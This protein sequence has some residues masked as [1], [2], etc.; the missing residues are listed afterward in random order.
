MGDS[1]EKASLWQRLW[2]GPA[3]WFLGIL[4]AGVAGYLTKSIE[5]GSIAAM[6]NWC[7][8]PSGIANIVALAAA[9]ILLLVMAAGCVHFAQAWRR[10]RAPPAPQPA[11]DPYRQFRGAIYGGRLWSWEHLNPSASPHDLKLLCPHDGT[12]LEREDLE[13]DDIVK[14]PCP[15]CGEMQKL[16][17]A[18]FA[19]IPPLIQRDVLTGNWVASQRAFDAGIRQLAAASKSTATAPVSRPRK[20]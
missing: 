17:R 3:K 14:K 7:W 2:H 9:A 1:R 12:G 4:A 13:D 5:D 6:W 10:R 16:E 8:Q 18:E 20:P 15:D 19:R 11:P